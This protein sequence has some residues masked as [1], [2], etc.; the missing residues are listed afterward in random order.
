MYT[1]SIVPTSIVPTSIVPTSKEINI[2]WIEKYRPSN[3]NDIV[4]DANNR[5]LF[6]NIISSKYFPNLLFYGPPGTGKTTTIINLINEYQLKNNGVID[7]SMFIHLNASDERGIDIIRNQ[8]HHFVKSMNLFKTG[9]KFVILDE[10]DYMTKNA[11]VALKYLLQSSIS[12]VRFCLICNYITKIDESLKNEFI[13]IRFNQLPKNDINQ[14][15]KIIANKENIEISDNMINVIQDLY[16]SDIRSMINFIQLNQQNCQNNQSSWDNS[17]MNKNVL[18]KIH[19]LFL[20]NESIPNIQQYM[21]EISIQ[22][23]TDKR[24]IIKKYMN[25]M[26]R[27]NPEFIY[28]QNT[29]LDISMLDIAENILHSNITN[30]DTCLYY[31][32][33]SVSKIY[34]DKNHSSINGDL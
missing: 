2:P 6:K 25:Y 26:I 10:V 14:F 11:Q 4:L 21:N 27:V 23:N 19:D 13:T 18:S 34:S 16:S 29:V 24:T 9:I 7:K 20:N 12:N 32:L 5:K 31:F 1:T 17:V 15:I 22:Y 3:F 33:V 28:I 8:I 30:I